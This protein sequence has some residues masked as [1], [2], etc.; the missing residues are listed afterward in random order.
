MRK[1][2]DK[3]SSHGSI[4]LARTSKRC[5]AGGQAQ[6]SRM[7]PLQAK[8]LFLELKRVKS[9]IFS[10]SAPTSGGQPVRL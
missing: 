8:I 1:N 4:A 9:I 2:M 7:V 10:G 3:R 5:H 6:L